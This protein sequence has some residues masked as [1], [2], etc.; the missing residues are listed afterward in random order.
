VDWGVTAGSVV[1]GGGGGSKSLGKQC[2][3]VLVCISKNGGSRIT[4]FVNINKKYSNYKLC[5]DDCT[6]L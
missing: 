1:W 4:I 2:S 5:F 6:P 3:P